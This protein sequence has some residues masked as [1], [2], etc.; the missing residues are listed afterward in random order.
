MGQPWGLSGPQF[1]G[2]YGAS[3]RVALFGF[4]A[5]PDRDLSDALVRG[6]EDEE[7]PDNG[8]SGCGGCGG[9]GG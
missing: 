4:T 6:T 9:C 5:V 2:I 8:V 7:S 1:L 3:L